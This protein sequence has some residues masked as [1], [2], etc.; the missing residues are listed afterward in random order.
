MVAATGTSMANYL[1]LATL[2]KPGDEVLIEHPTYELILA[3]ARQIGATITTISTHARRS[4]SRS[5]RRR[6]SGR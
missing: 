6:S 3:A 1:A 4:D 2:L 5:I